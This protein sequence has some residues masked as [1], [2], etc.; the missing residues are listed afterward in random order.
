[1]HVVVPRVSA[2]S[3]RRSEMGERTKVV[4][5]RVVAARE[6]SLGN[7]PAIDHGAAVF[8][9]RAIDRLG[10][11]ARAYGKVLRVARTIAHLEKT[12]TV[13]DAHVAEAL[14]YRVLDRSAEA[15]AA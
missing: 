6:R 10:L 8:L 15:N 4:R 13:A 1:M 11:S 2:R 3:L 9:E 12:D 5:E 14:S 7:E